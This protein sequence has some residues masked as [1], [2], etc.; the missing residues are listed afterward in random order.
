MEQNMVMAG[1]AAASLKEV[2]VFFVAVFA[3]PARFKDFILPGVWARRLCPLES[4]MFCFSK[5]FPLNT[6]A[7][8][9]MKIIV[10]AL[11][12]LPLFA[13]AP[14]SVQAPPP[15]QAP[16]PVLPALEE[17]RVLHEQFIVFRED[18]VFQRYGFTFNS[19]YADWLQR[20]R[21]IELDPPR[22][23]VARLLAGLSIA[24][25]IHGMNSEVYRQFEERFDQALRTPTPVE[26]DPAPRPVAVDVA[27][28]A[29]G[30]T[31]L[32]SGDTQGHVFPGPGLSGT[33]GGLAGRM[34]V[35]EHFRKEDPQ[36]LLLDAGDAFASASAGAE[37]M[38]K[39]LVR[40]MNRM[41]YDA[42]GLGSRELAMGEMALRELVGIAGFPM[43]CS[44][45]KFGKGVTPWI[46]RYALIERN[47]F[48]VAVMS[49]LPLPP[50]AGI[51][52]AR[53]IPPAEAL[54]EL[55]PE[56]WDMADC[57]V[58]LTQF[59][60]D[61]VIALL[62][63]NSEID[64]ILGDG[65][66]FSRE[67]PAY[68]PAVPEGRGFGLVRMEL[69]DGETQRAIQSMPVLLGPGTDSQFLE[70]MDEFK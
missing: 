25:R 49:L 60:G 64:V 26:N 30:I 50:G 47:R 42:M 16:A 53:F 21:D 52:G 10:F 58:L 27:P 9:N 5:E 37:M 69:G 57:I 62:D 51:T 54:R 43:L 23:E 28:S 56:L 33:V 38:N 4:S 66:A 68:V 45:L 36:M 2:A 1:V 32:F 31:I 3:V 67:S 14:R 8:K 17:L 22:A 65:G 41:R 11:C 55:L 34:P 63:E 61:E 15:A 12:L 18:D 46:K 29:S 39:T 70:M 7:G 6:I 44:N 24:Y 20:V 40:A 19:P 35:I 59:R 48:R 13:C